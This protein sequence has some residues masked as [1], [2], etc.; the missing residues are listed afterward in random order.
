MAELA[1]AAI[2]DRALCTQVDPQLFFP[3]KGEGTAEAKRVCR[4]CDVREQCLQ[5]A[6]RSGVSGVW[7]GMSHLERRRLGAPS[8]VTV[9][10]PVYTCGTEAG[11]MRHRRAGEAMC[12]PCRDAQTTAA[13]YRSRKRAARDVA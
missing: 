11:A 6:I 12:I 9:D 1:L 8:L 3:G 4:M 5:I 10:E 2:A 7:G 13:R